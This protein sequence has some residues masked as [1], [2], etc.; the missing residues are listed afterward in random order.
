MLGNAGNVES[1]FVLYSGRVAFRCFCSVT[2]LSREGVK[3][4]LIFR[5]L[6]RMMP[7]IDID[8]P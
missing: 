8:A 6:E 5:Y 2:R 4:I 1:L 3:S 7:H